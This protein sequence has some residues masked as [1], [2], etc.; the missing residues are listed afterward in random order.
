[1]RWLLGRRSTL[2]TESELLLYE[3]VNTQ[4]HGS[5][6]FSYGDQPPIPTSKSSSAFNP[7]LSHPF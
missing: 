2:S 7:K 4:T 3:V 5:M 6:E 1:M